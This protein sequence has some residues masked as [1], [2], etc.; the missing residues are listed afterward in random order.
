MRQSMLKKYSKIRHEMERLHNV[1]MSQYEH[2]EALDEITGQVQSAWR[3][4][5]IRRRKPTPQDEA[6][7]GLTYFYETIYNGLPVFLRR[8]DSALKHIGQPSL[9]LDTAI[10]NFGAW[11]GGDRDGNPF[12]TPDTTR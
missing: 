2:T 4:D 12:V 5:E 8:I 1:R 10:F 11:M 9:P 7:Q 6:R 3:T